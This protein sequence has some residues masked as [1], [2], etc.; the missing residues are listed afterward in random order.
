[1]NL[2]TTNL[3]NRFFPNKIRK[4]I[5]VVSFIIAVVL[6]LDRL[7]LGKYT[8]IRVH[9]T[10]DSW[11]PFLVVL[12]QNIKEYGFVAQFPNMLSGVSSFSGAVPMGCLAVN[13]ILPPLY[14][15][16]FY[17]LFYIFI[18][19]LGMFLLLHDDFKLSPKASFIGAIFF[20]SNHFFL[21]HVISVV[22][23]PLFLWTMKRILDQYYDFK[24]KLFLFLYIPIYFLFSNFYLAFVTALVFHLSYYFYL[25]DTK[26]NLKNLLI[27]VLVWSSFIVINLPSLAE[28]FS[29]LSMSHRSIWTYNS[30]DSWK[31]SF[32]GLLSLIDITRTAGSFSVLGLIIIFLFVSAKPFS[33][34]DKHVKFVLWWIIPVVI[35]LEFVMRTPVWAVLVANFGIFRSLQFERFVLVLPILYAIFIAL[36]CEHLAK[37]N[38]LKTR[39][40]WIVFLIILVL[41]ILIKIVKQILKAE[42]PRAPHLGFPTALLSVEFISAFVLALLFTLRSYLKPKMDLLTVFLLAFVVYAMTN[43]AYLRVNRG[44][45]N[46]HHFLSVEQVDQVKKREKGRI[47]DFRVA[48]IGNPEPSVLMYEGFHITEGYINIY[49]LSYY[50]YWKK[51]IEIELQKDK[52]LRSYFSPEARASNRVYL[53]DWSPQATIEHLNFDLDLLKLA[54]VKYLFSDRKVND[55]KQYELIQIAEKD[56]D[57]ISLPK[58]KK[59]F[60]KTPR[61]IYQN[62]EF[63]PLVFLTDKIDQ[64]EHTSELLTELG[65][66]D[67]SDLKKTTIAYNLPTVDFKNLDSSN[68]RILEST[69]TPDWIEVKLSNSKPIIL[70][71]MRNFHKNWICEI[72][73]QTVKPF[74]VYHTFTGVKVPANSKIVRF[75]Y[76]NP[77]FDLAKKHFLW[78]FL[79]LNMLII[80]L[81]RSKSPSFK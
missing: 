53:Y 22:G 51:V 49:P 47:R 23:I 77:Y 35:F 64:Y 60:M 30:I 62:K 6:N 28:V 41:C 46:F 32:L 2:S 74:P 9:D 75:K 31:K 72:D 33:R 20:S 79:F 73:G 36:G 34:N 29:N 1:M 5:F 58:R 3:Q 65:I 19:F 8:L 7:I 25:C 55:H 26:K 66:R 71:W 52:R 48:K 43:T 40:V 21:P 50:E 61:Y 10:F 78:V 57:Y 67:F 81:L 12:V 17:C 44:I 68:A 70:N 11:Y 63:A 45:K 14:G 39:K 24:K 54:G 59:F 15:Y 42:F 37:E 16:V 38:T 80:F 69:I 76:V 13:F 56:Q 18:A 27:V 4:H